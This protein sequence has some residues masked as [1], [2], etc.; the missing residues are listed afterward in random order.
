MTFQTALI[1]LCIQL[2]IHRMNQ[3]MLVF[4]MTKYVHSSLSLGNS[5]RSREIHRL[6]RHLVTHS[7]H[8]A[9]QS[10][11]LKSVSLRVYRLTFKSLQKPSAILIVHMCVL[12]VLSIKRK[13][14]QRYIYWIFTVYYS[15]TK[16]YFSEV[17][18]E[19]TRMKRKH[20][21]T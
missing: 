14:S 1:Q 16:Y 13:L 12:N 6:Q 10:V 2:C 3:N 17:Y 8:S 18:K 5:F 20:S 19:N 15:S 11:S 21:Q 4:D 7:L 9:R